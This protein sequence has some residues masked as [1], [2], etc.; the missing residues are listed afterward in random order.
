M[1][2]HGMDERKRSRFARRELNA[3]KM[4]RQAAA[5]RIRTHTIGIE[6][7][8]TANILIEVARCKA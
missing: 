1:E 3:V 5:S 4:L 8:T 7:K 2:T 6:Q